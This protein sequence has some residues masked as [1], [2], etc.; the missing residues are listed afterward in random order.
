MISIEKARNFIHAHGTMWERSLWDHLFDHGSL[1]RVHQCLLCYKNEDGGWGHGLEHDIKSPESN[2]LQVEFLLT[3]FRDTGIPTGNLLA[4]T[5]QWIED[6]LNEDGTLQNSTALSKYPLAPWWTEW[7]GQRQP[8]SITGNLI[9]HGACTPKLA[10]S[11]RQWVEKNLTLEKIDAN[12]WL[13]MAYHAHDYF[14][15]VV[16]YPNLDEH[17][18]AVINNIVKCAKQQAAKGE[19]KKYYTLFMFAT[20]PEGEVAQA[21]PGGLVAEY[22][23]HLE[24]SQRDDGGWDDE[25]GLAHWQPYSSIITLLALKNFN[26]L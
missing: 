23:E 18:Q 19:T 17:R 21:M 25:H 26:R 12:D 16:E 15:N 5:A 14:M 20:S 8:D 9:K 6:Q 11:T 2:P 3:I 13:F 10:Q 22:L 1:D 7:G 24:T 4:G